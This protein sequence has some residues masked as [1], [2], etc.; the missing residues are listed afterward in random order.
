MYTLPPRNEMD[1]TVY[2]LLLRAVSLRLRTSARMP[3]RNSAVEI[4]PSLF[5]SK[6]R[7]ACLRLTPACWNFACILWM[8]SADLSDHKERRCL[9]QRRQWMHMTKAPS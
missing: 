5:S 6:A 4:C 3:R 2:T 8:L 9:S 1:A 7:K